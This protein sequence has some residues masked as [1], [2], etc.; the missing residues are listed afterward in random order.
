MLPSTVIVACSLGSSCD[1]SLEAKFGPNL[2]RDVSMTFCVPSRLDVTFHATR[3]SASW[4]TKLPGSGWS[5]YAKDMSKVT[6]RV[7]GQRVHTACQKLMSGGFVGSRK[8]EG[9]MKQLE[10]DSCKDRGS[11]GCHKRASKMTA[12]QVAM[13]A[14]PSHREHDLMDE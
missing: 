10:I 8:S 6:C 1:S 14:S 3:S 5:R 7:L 4:L 9:T 12:V 2:L 13:S 11:D